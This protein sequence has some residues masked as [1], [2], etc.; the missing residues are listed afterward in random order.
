MSFKDVNNLRK[1]GKISEAYE[2]ALADLDNANP[3]DIWAVRAMS[4]VLVALLKQNASFENRDD[5]LKYLQEFKD[6]KIPEDEELVYTNFGYWIIK[7][8]YSVV[9]QSELNNSVLDS[10]V[11]IIKTI[12]YPIP[13]ELHSKL[14]SAI[15]KQSD[16]WHGFLDFVQW[17]NLNNLISDDYLEEEFKGK[18]M[19]TLAEKVYLSYAK[20][21]LATN[22]ED[23]TFI[24]KL[25]IL[26][27]KHPKF[28]YPQYYL[29]KL[30]LSTGDKEQAFKK[31]IPFA[32]K[33]QNDFWVW[34]LLSDT[35]QDINIK[36]SCF[37]KAL[38]CKSP[39]KMLV[40]VHER[41]ARLLIETK[42]YIYA[43]KEIQEVIEIR[44][45]E[46]WKI[47]DEILFWL[48]Q[49]WYKNS[50]EQKNNF[51]F[52]KNNSKIAEELLFLDIEPEIA[53]VSYINHEK[54]I[55]NFIVSKAKIGF[56]KYPQFFSDI[57][58]GNFIKIRL[59]KQKGKDEVFYKVLTAEKTDNL[60]NENIYKTFNGELKV[61][62]NKGF[63]FVD[64]I[65][66]PPYFVTENNLTSRNG[67]RVEGNAIMNYNKKREEW[68]WKVLTIK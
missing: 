33:K 48:E 56:F 49:D 38:T 4:W 62:E 5:F 61:I 54:S 35:Q 47:K 57:K 53:V 14:L 51:K 6:L 29:G 42:Q 50:K 16:N 66:I 45:K 21:M 28:I 22:Y 7:F 43:K 64:N 34:E 9:K 20:K 40:K 23:D 46:G 15:T 68:D 11:A 13:S 12:N 52:Y 10:F 19:M 25:E 67:E 17:W 59:L 26:T 24:Q 63:A 32:K 36:I 41:L 58:V 30:L 31:F 39:K 60:P 27:G 2:M 55:L 44:K 8:I 18:K 1:E 37:C 3:D 65:F